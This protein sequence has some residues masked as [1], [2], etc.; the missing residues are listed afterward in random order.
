MKTMRTKVQGFSLL[1]VLITIVV[2]AIGL[3]GVAGMQVASIK[4]AANADTRSKASAQVSQIYEQMISNR[5]GLANYAVGFGTTPSGTTTEQTQLRLWK[6]TLAAA[7]PG[8][9]GRIV[10]A[11]ADPSCG[12]AASAATVGFPCRNITVTVRWNESN[13]KRSGGGLVSFVSQTRI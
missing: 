3:L 9:D 2:V 10:V 5:A 6:E 7:L 13:T 12:L 4:L 1:E 11:A 8:G